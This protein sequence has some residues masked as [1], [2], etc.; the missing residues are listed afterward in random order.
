MT[1]FDARAPMA[2]AT[3]KRGVTGTRR[4]RTG[5]MRVEIGMTGGKAGEWVEAP[6]F[7]KARHGM[8]QTRYTVEVVRS[9]QP[10]AYADTENEFIVHVEQNRAAWKAPGSP[11]EWHPW[12]Y[13]KD[14]DPAG[15][16]K[17]FND[18]CD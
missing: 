3:G 5:P 1:R 15:S 18:W 6:Q 16:N 2:G 8:N 12:L 9:G 13:P 11:E 10:R 4:P 7:R 17:Y 14:S